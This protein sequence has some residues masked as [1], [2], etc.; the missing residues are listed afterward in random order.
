MTEETSKP[1]SR[2]GKSKP[3]SQAAAGSSTSSCPW[4][5]GADLIDSLLDPDSRVAQLLR[6]EEA[7]G[8]EGI[9]L[10]LIEA[11]IQQD[12]IPADLTKDLNPMKRGIAE[13]FG[14]VR[15]KPNMKNLTKSILSGLKFIKTAKLQINA[16]DKV[17]VT[18]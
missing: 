16:K 11:H 18:R 14:G 6:P 17:S 12:I 8:L 10:L 2:E 15:P 7:R 1:P 13:Q 5:N 4:K 3:P 9:R